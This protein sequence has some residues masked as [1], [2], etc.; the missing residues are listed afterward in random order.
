M[1]GLGRATSS[2]RTAST[3]AVPAQR[4]TSKYLLSDLPLRMQRLRPET[5]PGGPVVH[6]WTVDPSVSELGPSQPWP[7]SCE[8]WNR[9]LPWAGS[10]GW[11]CS[12]HE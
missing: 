9:G 4:G 8:G 12:G 11:L 6:L 5:W 1:R 3:V 2:V 10:A 7:R